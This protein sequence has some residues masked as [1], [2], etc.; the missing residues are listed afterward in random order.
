VQDRVQSLPAF[1]ILEPYGPAET[2]WIVRRK[3]YRLGLEAVN[4]IP[5][6]KTG[7]CFLNVMSALGRR[8]SREQA[9]RSAEDYRETVDFERGSCVPEDWG[10][11]CGS[12][13]LFSI[14]L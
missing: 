10:E 3:K 9:A 13:P 11:A 7:K 12:P 14:M 8:L 2:G 5:G 6:P 4:I 1:L